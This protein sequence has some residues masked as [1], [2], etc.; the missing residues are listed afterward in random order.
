MLNIGST[1][2]QGNVGVGQCIAYATSLGYTVSIPLNDSQEYDLI[3]DNGKL[4][5]VQVKTSRCLNASGK[6]RVDLKSS[7]WYTYNC[8]QNVASV[9]KLCQ[10]TLS[11]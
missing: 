8:F 11:Q 3:V 9:G 6:Y 5:K 10:E 1:K 2:T 7:S 4:N